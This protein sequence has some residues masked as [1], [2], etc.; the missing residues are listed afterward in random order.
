MARFSIVHLSDLHLADV[1]R[2]VDPF[3]I[4]KNFTQVIRNQGWLPPGWNQAWVSSHNPIVVIEAARRALLLAPDAVVITGDLATS[5]DV[6]DIATVSELLAS[7]PLPAAP[8]LAATPKG[9]TPGTLSTAKKLFTIPGNHDRYQAHWQQTYYDPGATTCDP[10]LGW[11]TG[12]TVVARGT[13]SSG[14]DNLSFVGIDCSL[15]ANDVGDVPFGHLAQGRVPPNFQGAVHRVH[16][17]LP[18]GAIAWLVHWPAEFQTFSYGHNLIGEAELLR[19][20][21]AEGVAFILSGH[22]HETR[23]YRTT[24]NIPVFC[25]GSTSQHVVAGGNDLLELKVTVAG[26]SATV[27]AAQWRY[28]LPRAEFRRMQALLIP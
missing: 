9:Q 8:W 18:A 6:A 7:P 12:A 28:D 2:Q 1:P 4:L 26:R 5:G 11:P 10:V 24:A 23:A 14:S 15:D 25:C 13:L 3:T 17:Q 27:N 19:V 20:A 22:T 16:A 21:R